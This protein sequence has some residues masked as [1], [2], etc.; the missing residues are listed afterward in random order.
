MLET[1]S[2]YVIE[3]KK[4]VTTWFLE[5]DFIFIQREVLCVMHL[6]VPVAVRVLLD[7]HFG[8]NSGY[9]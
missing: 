4:H 3:W 1:Y 7:M 2:Q 6:Y 9:R 5:Y 8:A